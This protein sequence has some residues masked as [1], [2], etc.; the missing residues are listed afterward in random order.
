MHLSFFSNDDY[1]KTAKRNLN[2]VLETQNADGS[3]P[4][5]SRPRKS[6]GKAAKF[7]E[8]ITYAGTAWATLGL[9]RTSEGGMRQ[10]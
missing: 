5:I 9:L 7:L 6:S 4:M 1:A 8:P 10:R 2:F 3:W